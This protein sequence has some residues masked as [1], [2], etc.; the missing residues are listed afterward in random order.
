[1]CGALLHMW[2]KIGD[3]QSKTSTSTPETTDPGTVA[4][5]FKHEYIRL[6]LGGHTD[7]MAHLI[8]V[9]NTFS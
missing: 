8:S 3:D 2:T 7:A 5:S 1:M 6:R 4:L 9:K